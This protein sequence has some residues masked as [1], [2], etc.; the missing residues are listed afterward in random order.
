MASVSEWI[1]REYFEQQGYL[2]IQPCK[3]FVDRKSV[4]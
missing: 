1:V 3:Y 4:V 2:V